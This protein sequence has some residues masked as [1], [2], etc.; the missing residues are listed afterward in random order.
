MKIRSLHHNRT[1]RKINALLNLIFFLSLGTA[2]ICGQ[3]GADLNNLKN[4]NYRIGPGDVIDI[5][6]SKNETLSRA[7]VRVN[8]EGTIQLAMLDNDFPVACRT[9]KELAEQIEEKYKKY[10]L[11]PH[12]IVAVKEFNSTPVTLIGEVN[13]PTRFP[14]QRPMRLLEVLALGNG[15]TAK[16]GTVVQIIRDPNINTCQQ[17]AATAEASV[18][19]VNFKLAEILKGNER[20]NP[21][22]QAGDVVRVMEAEEVK[23][24]QAYIIGNVKSPMT[25]DLKEPVTLTQAVAMAGGTSA[26]AQLDKVK[27]TRQVPGS[28]DTTSVA[29]NLKEVNKTNKGDIL[30]Q[31]NDIVEIPG[32]KKNIF[33]D[34]L[35]TIA[36]AVMRFPVPIP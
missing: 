9:E 6:V 16:A 12:V 33:T 24:V 25:V 7:G 10:L 19:L 22:L 28:L 2:Y 11:E 32:P 35:K 13:T 14:L 30:L 20:A 18:Q 4:E 3:Q 21:F 34:I 26:G 31:P 1:E 15:P 27:I 5:I 23:K 36:P 8:N 29:V 17:K